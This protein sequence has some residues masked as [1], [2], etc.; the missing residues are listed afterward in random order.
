MVGIAVSLSENPGVLVEFGGCSRSDSTR[1]ESRSS[2]ERENQLAQRRRCGN[3]N[4]GRQDAPVAFCPDC[5]EVVNHEIPP[6]RCSEDSHAK[7]RRAIR[8]YC[9]DCG[10]QLIG[11]A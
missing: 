5:G 11:G 9:V 2:L 1:S 6:K 7:R 8:H 10:E 3:M 4:H